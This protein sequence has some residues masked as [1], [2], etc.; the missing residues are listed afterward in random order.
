MTVA[1]PK[2]VILL[3]G[4]MD[5]STVLAKATQE[6]YECYCLSIAYGQVYPSELNA[7]KQIAKQFKAAAHH[8]AHVDLNLF[9]GSALTDPS[10]PVPRNAREIGVP[11]TY[12]PARNTILLSLGLAWAETLKAQDIFIGVNQVDYSGYPD[13]R[14]EFIEA[15]ERLANLGT[16]AEIEGRPIT[17]HAPLQYLSKADII[18]LGTELG[19]DFSETVSCYCA[20][21]NGYACG[22]CDSCRLRKQG[23]IDANIPDST[24]YR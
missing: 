14:K 6:G 10:L 24:K 15:Y 17:I 4:G 2:A 11:I 19:V 1:K 9:G 3:S 20:D 5:S 22:E 7:A 16:C 18:R 12:V 8:I 23:F 21:E 13:C